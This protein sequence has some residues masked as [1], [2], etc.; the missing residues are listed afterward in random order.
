MVVFRNPATPLNIT[1]SQYDILRL[2][3]LKAYVQQGPPDEKRIVLLPTDD[4][5]R[6]IAALRGLIPEPT[7]KDKAKA[8]AAT[9]KRPTPDTAA[10]SATKRPAPSTATRP[11]TPP[12]TK[13]GK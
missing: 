9:A 3:E 7:E 12:R 10:P 6:I 13:V 8:A 5:N 2:N 1:S 4:R 11:L